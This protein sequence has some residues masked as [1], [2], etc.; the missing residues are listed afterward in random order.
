MSR[1]RCARPRRLRR[2][3]LAGYGTST[4]EAYAR[5]LREWGRF[6]AALDV[7]VFEAHRVHVDAFVRQG[8]REG[9]RQPRSL[10]DCRHWLATT[11][12]RSTRA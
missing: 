3:F 2:A 11:P 10:D 9:C 8:E 5:D 12:T 6:L 4:R 1:P 7:G